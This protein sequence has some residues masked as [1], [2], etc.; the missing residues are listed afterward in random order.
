MGRTFEANFR[1][2]RPRLPLLPGADE[3]AR[4][5]EEPSEQRAAWPR[6]IARYLAAAGELTEVPSRSPGRWPPYWKSRVL[7]R[8]AAHFE[9][10][11]IS[12]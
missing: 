3:A 6:A 9:V 8:Q 11:Q 1:V 4:R 12:W 2:G 10:N 5:G 7:R